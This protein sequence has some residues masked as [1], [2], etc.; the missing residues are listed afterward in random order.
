MTYE[1]KPRFG[2][3]VADWHSKFAW[4]PINTYDRGWKWLCFVERRRIQKHYYLD[5]GGADF[6]W[7]YRARL[8]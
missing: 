2:S 1:A 6:W 4:L 3:S 8:R 5:G 7:Q